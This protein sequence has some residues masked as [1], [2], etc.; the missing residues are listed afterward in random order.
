MQRGT[1]LYRDRGNY[2]RKT[3]PEKISKAEETLNHEHFSRKDLNYNRRGEK[4]KREQGRKGGGLGH[5]LRRREPEKNKKAKE[6]EK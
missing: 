1:R 4:E 6:K 5:S 3:A 2:S